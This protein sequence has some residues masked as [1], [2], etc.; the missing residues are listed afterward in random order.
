MFISKPNFNADGG[1]NGGGNPNPPPKPNDPT[2]PPANG[3]TPP[4]AGDEAKEFETLLG[5]DAKTYT[6]AEKTRFEELK[7]KYNISYTG[8]DGKPLTPEQIAALKE[9][10]AKVKA[11]IDKP[12]DQRTPEEVKFLADN[13][14]PDGAQPTVYDKVNELR[15]MEPIDYGDLDPTSPEGIAH[16]EDIIEERAID[17]FERDLASKYPDAYRYMMHLAGGG[18]KDDFFA[19]QNED[20]RSIKIEANDKK[21]Q[22]VIMRKAL[23]LRGMSDELVDITVTA[24]KDSGKLLE[25]SQKELELLQAQQTQREQDNAK[26][27]QE[28]RKKE[29]NDINGFFDT[30]QGMVNKGFDNIEIPSADRDP[31]MKFLAAGIQYQNGVMFRVKRLDAKEL[32]KELKVAYFD[33]KGG[34][35]KD[36]VDRKAKSNQALRL[37]QSI[38]PTIT[39]KAEAPKVITALKDL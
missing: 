36:L 3:G 18:K 8:A 20:F 32:A 38:K 34:N 37:K 21:G 13:T 28:Q 6:E 10:E 11:I 9:T 1:D 12:E 33:F 19:P 25:T 23:S 14:E 22:E 30:V 7:G 39:P 29:E 17:A 27:V 26:K 31:F 15:E 4:P 35:L 5:K 2:N 16:R 24:L